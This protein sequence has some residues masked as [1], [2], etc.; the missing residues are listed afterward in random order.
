MTAMLLVF[1]GV[2][3]CGKS[4]YAA[5]S[6]EILGAEFVEGDDYHP[7]ANK[8]AMAAGV[9][10]D[11]EKRER[12][13]NDLMAAVNAIDADTVC[14][15]CSALS[16]RVRGWLQA[17]S[18]RPVTLIWLDASPATLEARLAARRGHFMKSAMLA[19]QLAA[20][21]P[22]SEAIRIDVEGTPEAILED[23]REVLARLA[24]S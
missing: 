5:A 4:T 3:G 6:A 15:S 20:L 12:W 24:A 13:I 17:Q 7:P 22:P 19:S 9:P 16:A 10:L 21:E 23:V 14:V 18:R 1:M 11:D 2:A 8:R